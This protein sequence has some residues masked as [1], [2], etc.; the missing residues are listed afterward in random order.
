MKLSPRP[1]DLENDTEL[2]RDFLT[3]RQYWQSLPPYWNTGKS[4]MALYLM[5]YEGK[6][7]SHILWED[8]ASGLYLS[9]T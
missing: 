8:E 6:N 3:G 9:F 1:V 2:L 7:S 5:M 4:R